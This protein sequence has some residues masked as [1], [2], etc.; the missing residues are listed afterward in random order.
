MSPTT[1]VGGGRGDR[2][3]H[4]RGRGAAVGTVV[5]PEPRPPP[6]GWRPPRGGRR[7]WSVAGTGAGATFTPAVNVGSVISRTTERLVRHPA[8]APDQAGRRDHRHADLDAL[9]GALV[10][11]DRL[12]EV[13]RRI[14]D[15]LGDDRGDVRPDGRLLNARSSS[16]SRI[17]ASASIDAPSC[18]VDLLAQL[19]V[20]VLDVV[21]VE[22][23][24]PARRTARRPRSITLPTGEMTST[25]TP[26]R[27][28]EHAAAAQV[29]R[30]EQRAT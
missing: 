27:A 30:D 7:P 8:D 28:V 6:A 16:S 3:R 26:P 10:D 24:V 29:E 9:V 17:C 11:L 18:C 23:A 21:V 25:E 22:D 15:D 14:T 1:V 19:V 12:L 20:L 4:R 5:A 2:R 13:R